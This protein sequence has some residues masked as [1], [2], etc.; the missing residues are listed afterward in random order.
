VAGEEIIEDDA[1]RVPWDAV[2]RAALLAGQFPPATQPISRQELTRWLGSRSRPAPLNLPLENLRFH[3]DLELGWQELGR[4][5]PGEA[6]LELPAGGY[7]LWEPGLELAGR[8]W[9][10]AASWRATGRLWEGAGPLAPDDPLTYPGWPLPAGQGGMRDA[11]TR[12]GDIRGELTRLV[13]GFRH[14][15]WSWAAGRLAARTGPG[16]T[17]ALILDRNA[18]SLA[19]MQLRR[20]EPFRWSGWLRPLAPGDFLLR[21]GRMSRREVRYKDEYGRQTKRARPWFFQWLMGWQ[22]ASFFRMTFTQG[23]MATPREG[24][25]W[26]DLLQINFPVIG[27]TWREMESGPITD[28]IF[29][30]QLELRWG[31]APLPLLPSEAGRAYWDYGGTDFLPG[32]PG[33]VF[34]EIS[35]P[36]SVVGV[37]LVSRRWDLILE[38]FN[39]YH[40]AVLWYSNSGY[41]EGYTQEGQV[42]GHVA[43]GGAEGGLVKVNLRAGRGRLQTRAWVRHTRWEHDRFL[44]GRARRTTVGV[45]LGRNP[46][47]PE[48]G[49]L[50]RAEL[51]WNRDSIDPDVGPETRG[52]SFLFL[53]RVSSY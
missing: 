2:R 53:I 20:H 52:D 51:R 12:D 5:E 37:E 8:R 16:V 31:R 29:A 47:A 36:A 4:A 28:R 19:M 11:C 46:L 32:G 33:G 7:F 42:L 35:L 48:T 43:G 40:P 21:V 23:A 9:W 27:T 24:T 44:P 45:E 18:P 39:T 10:A 14:G 49:R 15:G 22:P 17:G 41:S 6:G 26:P 13:L 30:A 34:P 25:L 3:Q 50:W 38:G 1:R